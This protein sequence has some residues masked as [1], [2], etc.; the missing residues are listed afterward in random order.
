VVSFTPGRFTPGDR[1]PG[2][3]WIECWVNL[4]AGL[5]DVEK[6]KHLALPGL[7]LRSLGR[8]A[9]S[10]LL[11]RLRYPGSDLSPTVLT[12]L[13]T[14]PRHFLQPSQIVFIQSLKSFGIKQFCSWYRSRKQITNRAEMGGTTGVLQNSVVQNWSPTTYTHYTTSLMRGSRKRWIDLGLRIRQEV[15]IIFLEKTFYGVNESQHTNIFINGS[16]RQNKIKWVYTCTT[17]SLCQR[18]SL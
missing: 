6:R 2:P 12:E 4:R 14:L 15:A 8:P 3:H 13:R 16:L 5:D 10:Q 17:A 11:Y 1:A 9:R 18:S 7:Q